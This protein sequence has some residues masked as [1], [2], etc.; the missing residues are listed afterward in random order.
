MGRSGPQERL[1]AINSERW[2]RQPLVQQHGRLKGHFTAINSRARPP[3][4]LIG[5]HGTPSEWQHSWLTGEGYVSVICR[6][7]QTAKWMAAQTLI[8]LELLNLSHRKPRYATFCRWTKWKR[9]VLGQNRKFSKCPV[10]HKRDV[11]T[12]IGKM[13]LFTGRMKYM[14]SFMFPYSSVM[15]LS[16]SRMEIKIWKWEYDQFALSFAN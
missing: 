5:R 6:K 14:H 9:N 1:A 10:L 12:F 8:S 13:K 16:W 7:Q 3:P 15:H 2:R 4:P 11:T